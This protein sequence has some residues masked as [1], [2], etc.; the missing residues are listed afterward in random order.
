MKAIGLMSG[1]SLDGVDVALIETD[2]EEV[3][4]FGPAGYRAYS[5]AERAMLREA[6]HAAARLTD[7]VARPGILADAQM[8]VTSAHAEAVEDFLKANGLRG[9]DIDVVGFHGQTV[10]H[11]APA[12]D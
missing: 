4:A 11:I 2:G 3:A 8:L 9:G 5:D 1:T 6:L 10:L 7:R 12:S